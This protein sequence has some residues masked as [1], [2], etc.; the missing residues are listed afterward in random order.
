MM[1][2]PQHRILVQSP[3]AERMF[4]VSE[5]L[6]AAKHLTGIAGIELAGELRD[7]SYFHLL[8]DRHEVVFANGARMESLYLGPMAQA[9]RPVM[10]IGEMSGILPSQICPCAVPLVRRLVSGPRA[11]RLAYRH[12]K[13]AVPL[14]APARA[15]EFGT[16]PVLARAFG[17]APCV[18]REAPLVRR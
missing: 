15:E 12:Q 6:A 16:D 17:I 2:S 11:R 1:V 18:I 14:Q 10:A 5:V 13:N 9:A 4:G 7:V 3:I 8:F